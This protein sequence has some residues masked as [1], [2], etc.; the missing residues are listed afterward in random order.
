MDIVYLSI[1]CIDPHLTEDRKFPVE[2]PMRLRRDS[3]VFEPH[4]PGKSLS[5]QAVIKRCA[6]PLDTQPED[7]LGR[8]TD[9]ACFM[10]NHTR[11]ICLHERDRQ[12]QQLQCAQPGRWR[13]QSPSEVFP[14][15]F[16]HVAAR[17]A[18]AGIYKYAYCIYSGKMLKLLQIWMHQSSFAQLL[19]Q[20]E[21]R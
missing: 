17:D 19:S 16:P 13:W 21:A 14:A 6:L 9:S 11:Y 18:P 20:A 5:L 15:C 3:Q 8:A 4:F 1:H 7:Q 12:I 10:Q 2:P